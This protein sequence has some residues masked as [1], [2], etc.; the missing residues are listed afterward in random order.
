MTPRYVMVY[1]SKHILKHNHYG[2][3]LDDKIKK[4]KLSE[5]YCIIFLR[6]KMKEKKGLL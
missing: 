1:Q 3:T 2:I 4:K 5:M 6:I